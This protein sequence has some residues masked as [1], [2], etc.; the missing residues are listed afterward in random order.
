MDSCEGFTGFDGITQLPVE[1]NA[2]SRE[3]IEAIRFHL[4]NAQVEVADYEKGREAWF[5]FLP[6]RLPGTIR[7]ALVQGDRLIK[8]GLASM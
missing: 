8:K 4:H 1:D 5:E 3:M 7:P 6:A 2:D